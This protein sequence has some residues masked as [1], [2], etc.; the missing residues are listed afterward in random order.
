[1]YGLRL[2]WLPSGQGSV[3][4]TLWTSHLLSLA[5]DFTYRNFRYIGR[6]KWTSILSYAT[7]SSF[8]LWKTSDWMISSGFYYHVYPACFL[9]FY[10]PLCF[11]Q[12][13]GKSPIPWEKEK[14]TRKRYLAWHISYAIRA[15]PLASQEKEPLRSVGFFRSSLHAR[16]TSATKFNKLFMLIHRLCWFLSKSPVRRFLLIHIWRNVWS[17]ALESFA[18]SWENVIQPPWSEVKLILVHKTKGAGQAQ[19]SRLKGSSIGM[20]NFDQP[21]SH[22]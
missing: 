10:Q 16:F 17:S 18:G 15:C 9:L 3:S 8:T 5:L 19:R 22:A 1:M 21:W 13:R 2:W 6:W 14:K 7:Y 20:F 11:C 12:Y 4:F